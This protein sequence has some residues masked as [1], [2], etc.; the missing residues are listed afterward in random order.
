[1]HAGRVPQLRVAPTLRAIEIDDLSNVRY[2]HS[3]AFKL[4]AALHYTSDEIDAF[5]EQIRSPAYVDQLLGTHALGAWV[6]A[7]MAGTAAWSPANDSGQTARISDVFVQ[8]LFGGLGLGTMLLRE[9]E[10]QAVHAG[11]RETSVRVSLNAVPFFMAQG[12][13]VTSHGVRSTPAGIDLQ[14]A[15]MRRSALQ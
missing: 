5:V 6:D 7:E 3:S 14:V 8:P 10:E 11:Y 1:M 2:V 15:F 4:M 9:V 12:Y 13:L